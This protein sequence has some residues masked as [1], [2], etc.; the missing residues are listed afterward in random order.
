M[1][2]KQKG[3]QLKLVSLV[4]YSGTVLTIKISA[5]CT[6]KSKLNF[7]SQSLLPYL[8]LPVRKFE[9]FLLPCDGNMYLIVRDGE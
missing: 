3:V 2:Q 8:L 6:G 9:G 4:L 5:E 1:I 7:F